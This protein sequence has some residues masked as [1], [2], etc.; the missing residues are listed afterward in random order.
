MI[1]LFPAQT[2][3]R[4]AKKYIYFEQHIQAI[5]CWVRFV[6]MKTCY[7][8]QRVICSVLHTVLSYGDWIA[9]R[10]K[11]PF[12]QRGTLLALTAVAF[13]L[14]FRHKRLV[15]SRVYT[16]YLVFL[17]SSENTSCEMTEFLQRIKETM[18]HMHCT[19]YT[20]EKSWR[21]VIC[22]LSRNTWLPSI[23]AKDIAGAWLQSVTPLIWH[24]LMQ[25]LLLS[26][27]ILQHSTPTV[28]RI[29][30][31]PRFTNISI[32]RFEWHGLSNCY[33][34]W[35]A[36]TVAARLVLFRSSDGY[37]GQ[38][39]DRML[40]V[41]LLLLQLVSCSGVIEARYINL[42]P[43]IIYALFSQALDLGWHLFHIGDLVALLS[44]KDVN[45]YR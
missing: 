1:G 10:W 39:L 13:V 28:H 45:G 18:R 31:G 6:I 42:L 38:S 3:F 7:L 24:S 21:T 29:L 32:R 40:A 22:G 41:I 33:C 9:M 14:S 17:F 43:F 27:A 23:C 25:R 34:P 12:H 36:Y 5:H 20:G 19:C 35:R 26:P 2:C 30:Q 37:Q 15:T 8:P 16:S 11:V 4:P 44:Y